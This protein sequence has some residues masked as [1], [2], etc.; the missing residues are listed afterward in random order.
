MATPLIDRLPV[1]PDTAQWP[2]WGTTARVVVTDPD[3]LA[4]ATAIVRAELAAVDLACSRFRDDSELSRLRH[5]GGRTVQVGPLLAELVRAALRA[6]ERTGGDVDPTVGNA[7]IDL[8]Y[9]QDI[10][11]VRDGPVRVVAAPVPGWR[12]VR[13]DGRSLTVPEGTVLDLGATAKALTADRCAALVAATCGAGVLVSLGGD[14]ATAGPGPAGGW[15]VLV[16]DR[17]GEPECSV[18]LR[19]GTA[20]ATSSTIGRSWRA[21][22]RLLHHIVDPATCQP[23]APVWR[24]V[25]IAGPTCLAANTV[26]TATL[27]RGLRAVAWLR[28]LGAPA[29]LVAA[30]GTLTRLNGWPAAEAPAEHQPA[31]RGPAAAETGAEG[32]R[33]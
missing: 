28:G 3:V 7:L 5:A 29:R 13:L 18:T 16:Q 23:A 2:V 31:R 6:A 21:G 15:R 30:D 19:A 32:G 17:P 22:G 14:I 26:S 20:L 12:R 24:T 9:D 1:G 33:S 8:G 27:V 11:L 10:E 25:S 4:E